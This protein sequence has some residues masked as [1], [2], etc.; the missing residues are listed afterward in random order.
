[1]II[2]ILVMV[3]ALLFQIFPTLKFVHPNARLLY[4]IFYMFLPLKNLCYLFKNFILRITS[5]LN[6]I[7]LYFMLRG[8]R[9]GLYVLS[10]SSATLLPQVFSST[11]LSTFADAWHRRLGH[12]NPRILHFLVKKKCHVHQLSLLLIVV[13]RH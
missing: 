12:P 10:E 8:S 11:C 5:F 1:M 4:L 6:F 7:P 9:D 3:R 2:C 13:A